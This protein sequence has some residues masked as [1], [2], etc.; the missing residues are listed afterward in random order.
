MKENKIEEENKEN[1][2]IININDNDDNNVNNDNEENYEYNFETDLL[3]YKFDY[4]SKFKSCKLE[5]KEK[6]KFILQLFLN[7]S[8]INMF[9]KV[10]SL[11]K[12]FE[13]YKEEKNNYMLYNI[14]YKLLK[15]F[16]EQR[17][18]SFYLNASTLFNS[19]FLS[20]QIN[21]FYVF[22]YFKDFKKI[23]NI[24]MKNYVNDEIQE[25]IVLKIK[26]YQS[27]FESV[28]IKDKIALLKEVI[29]NILEKNKNNNKK[30]EK[31]NN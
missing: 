21:Y 6:N 8:K 24:N 28:L 3:K 10:I 16:K 12:L 9:N 4:N 30:K 5:E 31:K 15:Y 18:P 11:Q 26:T 20:K 1:N 7:S 22:K 14:S 13:L 17:I 25:N 23:I 19:E 27:I 2:L 29:T